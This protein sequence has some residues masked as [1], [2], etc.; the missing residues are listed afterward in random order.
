[1]KINSTTTSGD[2]IEENN[3]DNINIFDVNFPSILSARLD[4]IDEINFG[5]INV[6]EH[7]FT[8]IN[9]KIEQLNNIDKSY[10]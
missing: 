7:M 5:D 4:V 1:M 10:L 8:K 3:I 6:V 2:D 9:D